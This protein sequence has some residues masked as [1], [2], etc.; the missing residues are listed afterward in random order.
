MQITPKNFF[1]LSYSTDMHG[2]FVKEKSNVMNF[3]S[4]SPNLKLWNDGHIPNWIMEGSP[5]FLYQSCKKFAE[6]FSVQKIFFN[7]Q[8]WGDG[9]ISVI[10]ELSLMT[11]LHRPVV[12]CS[13]G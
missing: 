12:A 2:R 4:T 11:F 9:S 10:I 3:W 6:T 1:S 8:N 7:V 5:D 13:F